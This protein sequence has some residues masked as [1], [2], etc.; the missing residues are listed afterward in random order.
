MDKNINSFLKIIADNQEF[1]IN[2]LL[3]NI[4]PKKVALKELVLELYKVDYLYDTENTICNE[5]AKQKQHYKYI[6][7]FK[8]QNEPVLLTFIKFISK[9]NKKY[10]YRKL[11]N[12]NVISYT[13]L[14][15]FNIP[16]S[17]YLNNF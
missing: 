1:D 7:K 6:L 4:H 15:E 17:D 5:N 16:M 12:V 2:N 13:K 11:Y 10:P 3:T 9:F 14:T 8:H